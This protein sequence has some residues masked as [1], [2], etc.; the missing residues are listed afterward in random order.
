MW[1]Y[2]SLSSNSLGECNEL[3]TIEFSIFS[4][5]RRMNAGSDVATITFF[6][7]FRLYEIMWT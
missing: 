7:V 5:V 3:D 1:M 4:F 6:I 2:I